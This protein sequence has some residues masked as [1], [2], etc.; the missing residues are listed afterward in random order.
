VEEAVGSELRRDIHLLVG[1]RTQAELYDLADLRA[2]EARTPW[3]RVVPVVSADP[4]FD[5][6][7]GMLP[8]VLDRFQDWSRHDVYVAGPPEM[9]ERTITW[10]DDLGV[11]AAQTR[12]DR[13]DF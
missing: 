10:L 13:L 3:L 7:H 4:S 1:A 5:G 8:D 2:L 11:P 12:Y 9:V 6:M